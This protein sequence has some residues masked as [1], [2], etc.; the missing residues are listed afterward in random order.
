MLIRTVHLLL[1]ASLLACSSTESAGDR[2]K[3]ENIAGG[4]EVV[5][6]MTWRDATGC[7]REVLRTTGELELGNALSATAECNSEIVVFAAENAMSVSTPAWTDSDDD[8]HT[9]TMQPIIEV[10]VRVWIAHPDAVERAPLEVANATL[11]Y[12][13]NRVG[14]QFVPE[15]RNVF[16]D[17]EAVRTIG[18]GCH[19]IGAIHRSHLYKAKTLN[20]YYVG[21]VDPPPDLAGAPALNC[22]RFGDAN[23]T[24]I[25][26][27]AN[28]AALA[29]EI[30]HAFGLRPGTEGGHTDTVTGF[31]KNN[32]MWAFNGGPTRSHL[33]LGQVFRMNTKHDEFGGTMLIANGLRPGP[34]RECPLL[35]PRSTCPP[36][37]LDWK[38]PTPGT[39]GVRPVAVGAGQAFASRNTLREELEARYDQ[40]VQQSKKISNPPITMSKGRFVQ[41]GL[42]QSD[43]Q[44]HSP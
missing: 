34:A 36:L 38:P 28:F 6:M 32:V 3:I 11:I 44:P 22:D 29:H 23:V 13:Q 1:V 33:S 15:I 35:L 20:I 21:V 39:A 9:I 30:G 7:H 19:A 8:I 25:G 4:D 18:N 17:V 24:F 12:R 31:N 43:G 10:P 37:N 2:L 40:L 42:D 16:S 14:V 41:L 27:A 26:S 5:V